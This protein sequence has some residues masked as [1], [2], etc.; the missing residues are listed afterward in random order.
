[1]RKIHHKDFAEFKSPN[2]EKLRKWLAKGILLI[3]KIPLSSSPFIARNSETRDKER[4][5]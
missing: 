2:P 5:I 1:M 4:E 3:V